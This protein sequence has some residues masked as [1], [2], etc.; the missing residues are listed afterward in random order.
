[1]IKS[2]LITFEKIS[3]K[4]ITFLSKN[5]WVPHFVDKLWSGQA[6]RANKLMWGIPFQENIIKI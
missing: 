6:S 3:K 5:I 1:M 2:K 4:L